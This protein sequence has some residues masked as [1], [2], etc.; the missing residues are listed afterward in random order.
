M[1]EAAQADYEALRYATLAGIP[2]LG[3]AAARFERRGLAGLIAWPA[4]EPVFEAVLVG[5]LRPPWASHADPRLEA[6]G[7][8]YR[9][10]LA[11]PEGEVLSLRGSR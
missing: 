9:V 2:L 10:L 1:A 3:P 4:S 11:W 6:L 7:E 8:A 5:A